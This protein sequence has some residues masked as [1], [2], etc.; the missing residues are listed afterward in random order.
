M[1]RSKKKRELMSDKLKA[2]PKPELSYTW[3][4]FFSFPNKRPYLT[5]SILVLTAVQAA[6]ESRRPAGH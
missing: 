3:P 2:D 6:E 5:V 1:D 4:N